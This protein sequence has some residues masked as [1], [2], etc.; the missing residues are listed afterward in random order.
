[1]S[2]FVL[3]PGSTGCLHRGTPATDTKPLLSL[4]HETCR[5]AGFALE[6]P[7]S[8]SAVRSFT[9]WRLTHAFEP[10]VTLV[11]HHVCPVFAVVDAAP[12]DLGLGRRVVDWQADELARAAD[13]GWH[14]LT[15]DE[16]ARSVSSSVL[17]ELT[18]EE[19]REIT[20]W[21]PQT[22]GEVVFNHWD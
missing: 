8:S 15:A 17:T 14:R 18:A 12:D 3:T 16:A 13:L 9:A 7:T 6:G 4:I 22:V 1:M 20:Y 5:A 11:V 21:K 10:S 2:G 19:R